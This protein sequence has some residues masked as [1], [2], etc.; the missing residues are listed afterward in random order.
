MGLAPNG[1]M[2]VS[3]SS[4]G[5]VTLYGDGPTPLGDPQT[6]TNNPASP[7]PVLGTCN[8][9]CGGSNPGCTSGFI[10]KSPEN[11]CRNS[12]YPDR[13]DCYSGTIRNCNES[14]NSGDMRCA[15]H[16]SCIDG[17][18][19]LAS[20]P[21]STSCS[22]PSPTSAITTSPTSGTQPSPTG[23]ADVLGAK[24]A[25]SGEAEKDFWKESGAVDERVKG[26]DTDEVTAGNKKK[27][28]IYLVLGIGTLLAGANLAYQYFKAK[29]AA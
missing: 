18:C 23:S 9:S 8:S 13:S 27:N 12:N 22:V 24:T 19:R 5:T 6:I 28:I 15:S 3:V 17:S 16:L 21:G 11:V 20:Y 25:A 1:S 10:C 7:T 2:T 29:K 14:C 4:T 26:A